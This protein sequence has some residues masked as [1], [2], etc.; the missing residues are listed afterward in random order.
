VIAERFSRRPIAALHLGFAPVT[1]SLKSK[2]GIPA[3]SLGPGLA[4]QTTA[5]KIKHKPCIDEWS[6]TPQS[7]DGT[8]RIDDAYLGGERNSAQSWSA[9]SPCTTPIDGRRSNHTRAS[10]P[11]TFAAA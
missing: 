10:P 9:V 7:A 8:D 3:L 1:T 6:G 4:H 5:W 2:G 11:L